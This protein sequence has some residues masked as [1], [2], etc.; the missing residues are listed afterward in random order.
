MRLTPWTKAPFGSLEGIGGAPQ[1]RFQ[2]AQRADPTRAGAR[3]GRC[4]SGLNGNEKTAKTERSFRHAK[5]NVS[6]RIG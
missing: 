4:A 1:A 5:R 6:R 3:P 2:L